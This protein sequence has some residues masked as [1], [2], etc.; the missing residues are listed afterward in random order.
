MF[1]IYFVKYIYRHTS[2]SYKSMHKQS[3]GTEIYNYTEG[4]DCYI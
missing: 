2:G 4:S 1:A 3:F